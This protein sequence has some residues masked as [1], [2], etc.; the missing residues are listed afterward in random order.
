MK[1]II[2]VVW[3]RWGTH[4]RGGAGR[5]GLSR[6]DGLASGHRS[7]R[8]HGSGRGELV[9]RSWQLSREPVRPSQE[10]GG[11]LPSSR[12]TIAELPRS[13]VHRNAMDFCRPA[14][15]GRADRG[16]VPR[17][18]QLAGACHRRHR[19]A[20]PGIVPGKCANWLF[21]KPPTTECSRNGFSRTTRGRRRAPRRYGGS[22]SPSSGKWRKP[23]RCCREK[24]SRRSCAC[25]CNVS[26]C[27]QFPRRF[28][29]GV[30]QPR[31]GFPSCG[32]RAAD[33]FCRR[34]RPGRSILR[35]NDHFRDLAKSIRAEPIQVGPVRVGPA[36]EPSS[37]R[38]PRDTSDRPAAEASRR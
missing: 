24:R 22:S 9:S 12:I 13:W 23:R 37:R 35:H 31:A 2:A 18:S 34:T 17:L 28:V 30:R 8:R 32:P 5:D 19:N 21:L 16:S 25:C 14:C 7:P 29:P 38:K 3:A 4:G 6:L 27:R 33:R 15:C 1:G 20:P 10:A 26:L 36:A 11:Q